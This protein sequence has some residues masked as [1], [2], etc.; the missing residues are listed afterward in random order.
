MCERIVY[1]DKKTNLRA[2]QRNHQ[3]SDLEI[4]TPK[5]SPTKRSGTSGSLYLA[6]D[7]HEKVQRVK[8]RLDKF[9]TVSIK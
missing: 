7:F 5:K 3:Q 8:T 4:P 1:M 6:I 2:A 9:P